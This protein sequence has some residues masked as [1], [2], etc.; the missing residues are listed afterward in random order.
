MA[1]FNVFG[2]TF[3]VGG[4]V[5]AMIALENLGLVLVDVYIVTRQVPVPDTLEVASILKSVCVKQRVFK[6]SF[7]YRQNLLADTKRPG[8]RCA[9]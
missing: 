9:F 3:L 1:I 5:G 7:F 4:F 6:C 8:F 2:K